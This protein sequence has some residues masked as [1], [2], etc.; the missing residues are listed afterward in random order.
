MRIR[1]T[2]NILI[3]CLLVPL[4]VF[5]WM[6]RRQPPDRSIP[7]CGGEMMSLTNCPVGPFFLQTDAAW[8]DDMLG[9]SGEPLSAVGCTICCVSMAF[10]HLGVEIDPAELNDALKAN[11]GYTRQGW[12]IWDAAESVADG[13]VRIDVPRKP[14]CE[15]IDSFLRA[16]GFAVTKV[17]LWERVPHWVLI[18]GK[19]G[20]DYLIKNP[21]DE[22]QSICRLSALSGRIR[23]VRLIRRNF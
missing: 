3:L 15:L 12:L 18:V 17:L 20:D 22:T 11:G 7:A 13:A 1:K 14:S 9:G 2:I 10:T 5:V 16:G 23:S 6:R 19:D 8:A 4:L 21:L